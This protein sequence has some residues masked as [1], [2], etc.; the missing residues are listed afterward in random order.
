MKP[1]PERK[2][3]RGWEGRERGED[4][5]TARDLCAVISPFLCL[6]HFG[7]LGTSGD[8]IPGWCYLYHG[9]L[10]PIQLR[11][12]ISTLGKDSFL[13]PKDAVTNGIK[14]MRVAHEQIVLFQFD[15]HSAKIVETQRVISRT[16]WVIL[17]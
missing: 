5:D 17:R 14:A 6:I 13:I 1:K 16:L 3:G 8:P 12:A 9:R 10:F 2:E 11:P 7:Q 15:S 4:G